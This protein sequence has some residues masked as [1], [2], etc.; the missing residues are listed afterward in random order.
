MYLYIH[1]YID[2]HTYPIIFIYLFIVGDDD[3]SEVI[4]FEIFNALFVVSD[5]DFICTFGLE[6]FLKCVKK[7]NIDVS[8]SEA[9]RL[10]SEYDV[11]KVCHL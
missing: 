9:R 1:I 10:M 4:L 7:I 11:D 2:I 8:I 3:L 6:E 5:T